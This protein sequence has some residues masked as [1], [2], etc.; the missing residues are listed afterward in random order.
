MDR[1]VVE[2]AR[3]GD[4]EAFADLVHQI[5]DTLLGVA[6]RILRDPTLAEDVLQNALL[7]I[8]RKLPH[9][10]D[11]DH[12]EGWAFR[13]V[14]HACYSDA[15]RNR[16]WASTIRVLPMQLASDVDDIQKVSDRDELER[17]FRRLPL[18]QRAVFVLHHH[19]GLP[20]RGGGRDA[21][22]PGRH[23]PVAA[24]LRHPG[25]P[26]RVRPVTCGIRHSA[27]AR[28][29]GMN[30]KADFDRITDEWLNEG[31]DLTP[32]HVTDAVLLAVRTTPQE[33]DYGIPLGN[34]FMKYPVYAVAVLASLAVAG[35][36][37]FYAFGA[38]PNIGSDAAPAP[39]TQETDAP[40]PTPLPSSPIDTTSWTAF[41]SDRYPLTLRY[42]ANWIAQPARLDWTLAE[43]ADNWLSTAQDAFVGDNVRVSA[44]SVPVDR[45]A[46]PE[47]AAAVR[48]WAVDYCEQASGA[49]CEIPEG[50]VP[51]CV[52]VRDCHPGLLVP[53]PTEVSAFFTGG[54]YGDTMTV[55][56]V[57]RGE[58]EPATAPFGGSQRLLEAFLSTMDVWT[59]PARQDRI[60]ELEA[61]AGG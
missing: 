24:A 28:T 8:W 27:Q 58:N 50:A 34:L 38:G 4:Q 51:L 5:S 10:R 18:D 25:P 31:S 23:G 22:H 14:V 9:L 55:V 26:G 33:R 46:T 48:A 17:A 21:R 39:S 47:T 42:P 60:D 57:W 49:A 16:R 1:D 43:D 6:R 45:D 20:H 36:A 61:G 44:W 13:I 37:A 15:P 12:F 35:I 7:T 59:E 53:W 19:V 40:A 3:S 32:P 11:A 2:R 29:T 56:T 41:D 52:E 54:G 30:S